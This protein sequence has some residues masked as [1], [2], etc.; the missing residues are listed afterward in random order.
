MKKNIFII[1]L[2]FSQILLPQTPQSR[3]YNGD[4][5][6]Y[7]S[8]TLYLGDVGTFGCQS[9]AQWGDNWA[10]WRIVIRNNNPSIADGIYGIYQDNFFSQE[11]KI[12]NS[13]R[14]TQTGTWYWGIQ[15]YYGKDPSLWY[16]RNNASWYNM[17]EIPT[18]N[19]TIE[20]LPLNNPTA[21]TITPGDNSISLNWSKDAQGHNVMIV[22]KSTDQSFTEPT[23]G[24]AYTVGTGIGSG[25]VVYNGSGISF[26]D[27][28]VAYGTSYDYKLYSENYSYYSSGTLAE[29]ITPLPV[30]LSSFTANSGKSNVI[31]SWSTSTETNN[32]GFEIERSDKELSWQK[33]GFINGSGNSNSV[34]N[35]SYTDNTATAG[36]FKYRLKQIDTDGSFKYSPEIEAVQNNIPEG[37]LAAQNYPNPFNPA[38]TIK[39]G[40]DNSTSAAVII[41]DQ[42]GNKVTEIFRG[43]AEAGK[44]Y[45]VEFDGAGL[46]SGIYY[47]R[48]ETPQNS[49]TL[50]MLL[51]K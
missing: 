35:Y 2:V 38:T 6:P 15:V 36:S 49:K 11:P 30:E 9:W 23:Q 26:N 21:G 19:L 33:I 27:E 8:S 4:V 16:C 48:I 14:F 31:L 47:Y 10:K 34:K 20:I 51:M 32:F 37:F 1:I 3:N 43:N 12:A 13:P 18:S 46:S 17:W 42:L 45:N 29:H 25:I 44:I 28:G 5:N 7:Q 40:F 24:T 22:R 39:F 50:K 41:Y